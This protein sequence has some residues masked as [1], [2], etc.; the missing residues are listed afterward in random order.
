MYS[1]LS[2]IEARF[3]VSTLSTD[4]EESFINLPRILVFIEIGIAVTSGILLQKQMRILVRPGPVLFQQS[5]LFVVKYLIILNR[6][7]S[8]IVHLVVSAVAI[9]LLGGVFLPENPGLDKQHP[10]DADQT[11]H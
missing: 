4:L 3:L 1:D 11:Y 2:H 8:K 9:F 10:W 7:V 6:I 5:Y